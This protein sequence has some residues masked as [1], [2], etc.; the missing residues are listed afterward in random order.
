MEE[1]F[2]TID[3]VAEL[4]DMHHKTIRKFIS[5]GKL[6]ATKVGKQWRISER[7]LNF[8]MGKSINE[9]NN[10]KEIKVDE[11]I[12]FST[13]EIN[14]EIIRPKVS[15]STVVEINEIDTKQYMRISN[16]LIAVMNSKDPSLSD[17]TINMKYYEKENRLRIILWGPIAFMVVMLDTISI[18]TEPTN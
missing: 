3:Q 5:D 2:Y 12:E 14:S 10:N 16:T 11:E 15:I 7:D 9:N 13:N 1:K 8:F 17:S 4:L 18:L 6:K